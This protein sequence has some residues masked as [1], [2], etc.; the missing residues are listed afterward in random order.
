MLEVL[1]LE[2]LFTRNVSKNSRKCARTVWI[3]NSHWKAIL[4]KGTMWGAR[5]FARRLHNNKASRHVF[6]LFSQ[7]LVSAFVI[8]QPICLA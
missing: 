8:F 5:I 3:N 2:I 1:M 6:K 7:L 4:V